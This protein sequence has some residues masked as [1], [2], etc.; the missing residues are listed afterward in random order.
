[1]M[2]QVILGPPLPWG[3]FIACAVSAATKAAVAT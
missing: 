2:L 3:F 1:M